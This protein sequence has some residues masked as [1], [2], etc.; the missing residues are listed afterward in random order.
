MEPVGE[1]QADRK[2]LRLIMERLYRAGGMEYLL[3]EI[4]EMLE[5]DVADMPTPQS[6]RYGRLTERLKNLRQWWTRETTLGRRSL[7][8]K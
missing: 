2:M 1:L 4:V 5:Q 7:Y 6:G 3:N 8:Q